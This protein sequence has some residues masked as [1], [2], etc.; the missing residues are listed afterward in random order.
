MDHLF[1]LEYAHSSELL[2]MFVLR[3]MVGFAGPKAV[4]QRDIAERALLSVRTVGTVLAALEERG[5]IKRSRNSAPMQRLADTIKLTRIARA[6]LPEPVALLA[7]ESGA[8]GN[9][10]G[11]IEIAQ[12]LLQKLL[13]DSDS[14]ERLRLARASR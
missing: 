5:Y 13:S 2:V 7:P 6:P 3:D 12:Q 9:K 4:S 10:F 11:G 1:T 14:D 8:T